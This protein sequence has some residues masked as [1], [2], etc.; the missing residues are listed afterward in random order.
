MS[1]VGEG[2]VGRW[3]DGEGSGFVGYFATTFSK[4][5]ATGA[6]VDKFDV[7]IEKAVQEANA[8]AAICVQRRGA[9]QSIPFA[10]E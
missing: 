10:Y 4:F 6:T 3:A 9:M 8:A 1:C 2:G 7:E 5:V